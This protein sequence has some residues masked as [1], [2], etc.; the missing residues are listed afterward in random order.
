MHRAD[1]RDDA[2]VAAA[3]AAGHPDAL[4]RAYQRWGAEIHGMACRAVGSG[5][6]AED[7]TQQ[8]FISA[9]TGRA[10]YRPEHGSL[11]AWLVGILRHRIADSYARRRRDERVAL[12]SAGVVRLTGGAVDAEHDQVTDRVVLMEELRRIGPPQQT[13]MELAFFHDLTHEAIA[14]RLDLPLGTV[15]SHIRRTLARLRDR[16]EEV[17]GGAL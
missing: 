16:L 3:F 14:E 12:G 5:H 4:S 10:G 1:A 6:D 13:I 7:L 15:K 11:G 17:D 9:W 2:D 8:V